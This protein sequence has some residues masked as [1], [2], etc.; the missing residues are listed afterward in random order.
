M[1]RLCDVIPIDQQPL[2]AISA[3]DSLHRAA[4]LM[5]KHHVGALPV[6]SASRCVGGILSRRDLLTAVADGLAL[7]DTPAED[8]MT[9]E[10]IAVPETETVEYAV[11]IMRRAGVKHMPVTRGPEVV[12]VASWGPLLLALEEE[13]RSELSTLQEYV[14]G[15]DPVK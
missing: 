13:T 1:K 2:V 8:L 12:G 10:V 3:R 4:T 6:L 14:F 9:T 7:K 5:S 11:D 15:P